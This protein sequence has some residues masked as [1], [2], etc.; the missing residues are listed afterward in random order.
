MGDDAVPIHVRLRDER[1]GAGL[2]MADCADAMGVHY[3]QWW[4]WER[5]ERK[6]NRRQLTLLRRV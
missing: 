6:M 5:G 3:S 1:E 4:R 2:T